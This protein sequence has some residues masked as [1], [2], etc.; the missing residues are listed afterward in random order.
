ML[1]LLRYCFVIREKTGN[2]SNEKKKRVLGEVSKERY[3]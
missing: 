2:I 1:R 3:R